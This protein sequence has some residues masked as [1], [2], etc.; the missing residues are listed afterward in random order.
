MKI[1][2][3]VKHVPDTAASIKLAGDKGFEDSEIKFVSNPYDEYGLEEAVSL[4]EKQG[5]EVVVVTVGK[6][7]AVTTIRSAMAM[8]A[9]RAILVK[10]DS[11]FLDSD[12]TAK[13][14]KAVMD[15]DGKPDM[16][17]TGK[18]SV[19]TESFQTQYR[20]AE[21]FGMPV[22][23]EVSSLT[24]DE[25][26]AIAQREAE[27]GE[28]QVIEMSLP[29]VIGATKGLNEPRYPKFPDIM[30]AKKKEIKEIELSELGIDVSQGKVTIEK[31]ES[32]PERSGAK[33]LAGSV[34]DQVTELVRILK[35]DEKVL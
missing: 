23:N 14:L 33:M 19:D 3:C 2:V 30:K 6:A 10:T 22:V 28:I 29:C 32:V 25:G 34:D 1:C 17:F 4:V 8:G 18:G 27:G 15:Q 20:L 5:G 26:K 24:I 21:F 31:L 13:A 16:I 11:Q 7:S 9:H 35:E 12:L